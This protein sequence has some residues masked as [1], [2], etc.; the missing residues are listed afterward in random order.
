MS[1]KKPALW[2][3]LITL[4]IYAYIYIPIIILIISAVRSPMRRLY[5]CFTYRITA[6]SI[7]SPAILSDLE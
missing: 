6:L 4:L 3:R 1:E 2:L 7:L 5:F